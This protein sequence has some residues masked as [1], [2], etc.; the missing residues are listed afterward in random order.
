V[1]ATLVEFVR[2][3]HHRSARAHH[4]GESG[5]DSG[6]DESEAGFRGR[7][8]NRELGFGP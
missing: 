4:R 2:P 1:A 8:R 7:R 5:G 3:L 6:P